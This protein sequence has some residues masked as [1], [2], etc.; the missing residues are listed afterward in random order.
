L[1]AAAGASGADQLAAHKFGSVDFAR[2]GVGSC[3]IA[4]RHG[5]LTREIA[6]EVILVGSSSSSTQRWKISADRFQV[7]SDIKNP[8]SLVLRR[9]LSPTT[10]VKS[11]SI[12]QINSDTIPKHAKVI[13][14]I[15]AEKPFLVNMEGEEM[16]HFKGITDNAD[17]L[18]W[19]TGG[20]L[21]SG[22][23]PE[24]SIAYGLSRALM[25]EQP[26]LKF[27]VFDV[28]TSFQDL[29]HTAQ[30]IIG[31]LFDKFS[32]GHVQTDFEFMQDKEGLVHVSRFVPDETLNQTFRERMGGDKTMTALGDAGAVRLC[33]EK[34]RYFETLYFNQQDAKKVG[35]D[36]GEGFV[37][38]DVKAVGLNAKVGPYLMLRQS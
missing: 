16:A 34:P 14:V 27:S 23:Q 20:S 29:E 3:L 15:E 37:E 25:L 19:V 10:S 36:L 24:F 26:S 30:N 17:D 32:A 13:S 35:L 28:D 33:I 11:Y 18:V 4:K 12:D 1:L 8:L 22:E 38:V 2:N 6:D 31:T 9:L 7:Y 5:E 21:L